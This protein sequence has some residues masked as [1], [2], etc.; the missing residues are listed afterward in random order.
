VTAAV[1]SVAAS[2]A[3][4]RIKL[5]D[6]LLRANPRLTLI[7]FAG[8]SEEQG[9]GLGTLANDPTLYGALRDERGAVKVVDH[10]SARLIELL[11]E[12][13]R[14]PNELA[15]D[16]AS[17]TRLVLDD[18]LEIE[19][20]AGEFVSGS[21]AYDLV[22]DVRS[23]PV[24]MTKT[25]RLSQAALQYGERLDMDDAL[26]LSARLYFYGRVPVSPH[27]LARLPSRTSV[28]RF[29]GIEGRGALA[30]RLRRSWRAATLEPPNDGWFLWSG[31]A[32]S[33]P[34]VS[35]DRFKLYVSP[36]PE[37]VPAALAAAV[38]V[39]EE[40]DAEALKVGNDAMSLLRPD[41]I[42]LYF[43]DFDRVSA[44]ST[45]LAAE[46]AGCP[47]HGVPF[48]A[49]LGDSDG[50]LSWGI[51]PPRS[52]HMLEW[53]E[54]ESWRLWVTNRLAVALVAARRDGG[55]LA[56]WRYALAR[57]ELDGIN[58]ST[59]APRGDLWDEAT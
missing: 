28:E 15:A 49:E 59:W 38:V 18:V 7:P 30:R 9:A 47:G 36:L 41:K 35:S 16:E 21:R 17:L 12:S 46:L 57:I 51:D 10:E 52:E 48:T 34:G 23:P 43:N 1:E 29:L 14:V 37:S 32:A 6:A 54:R 39:G 42:V 31:R 19:T 26:R 45:A 27:W 53:Q 55:A 58:P 2:P 3:R 24:P 50:L 5:T 33:S 13:R 20:S 44:A 56:P 25:A 40:V 11:R 4:P 22:C 8:L